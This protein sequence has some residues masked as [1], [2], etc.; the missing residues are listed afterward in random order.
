[1][2][3]I[4]NIIKKYNKIIFK[5][6]CYITDILCKSHFEMSQEKLKN[7]KCKCRI[8]LPSMLF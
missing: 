6:S 7:I 1:M 8:L 3:K 2:K 4:Q 5:I